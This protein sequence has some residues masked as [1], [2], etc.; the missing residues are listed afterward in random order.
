MIAHVRARHAFLAFAIYIASCSAQPTGTG[1]PLL[2][3]QPSTA[4]AAAGQWLFVSEAPGSSGGAGTG[5]VEAYPPPAPYRN[6]IR[7]TAGINGP[8]RIAVD[9]KN[10]LFVGNLGSGA[11]TI[12]RYADRFKQPVTLSG[13]L[14]FSTPT[15]FAIDRKDDLWVSVLNYATGASE[16]VELAAPYAKVTRKIGTQSFGENLAF[17][18]KND[19]VTSDA[20]GLWIYRAPTYASAVTV[21][22]PPESNVSTLAISRQNQLFVSLDKGAAQEAELLEYAISATGV[23]PVYALNVPLASALAFSPNGNLYVGLPN[24]V[25]EIRPPYR[26]VVHL[27]QPAAGSSFEQIA[28]DD[29]GNVYAAPLDF[30]ALEYLTYPY[31]G[32]WQELILD[33]F[34][35]DVTFGPTV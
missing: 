25:F 23:K 1:A 11:I 9:S 15:A 26:R 21:K 29:A 31:R 6:P 20:A 3:A 22:L 10:D 14:V 13:K 19:L 28:V 7:I 12:Y 24:R 33:D 27:A 32:K 16:L 5:E 8:Y 18:S 2:P 17:D 35:S 30:S 4:G 34:P